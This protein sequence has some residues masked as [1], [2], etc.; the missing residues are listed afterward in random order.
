MSERN[1]YVLC[2]DNC[3]FESMTK[4]QILAAITDAVESGEIHDVDTGFVT[5][6]K[7][8]NKNRQLKF[9]VGT[10]AEY[11]QLEEIEQNVMY[12]ISDP[13]GEQE[14]EAEVNELKEQVDKLKS[15]LPES[16]SGYI[17]FADGTLKQWGSAG[18]KGLPNIGAFDYD[19]HIIFNIPFINA[20][21]N[22]QVT[23]IVDAYESEKYK[24]S[25]TFVSTLKSVDSM[26]IVRVNRS[27]VH[28]GG[29]YWEA[30][31]RWY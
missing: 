12:L 11:N 10:Q 3:R 13:H 17:K 27:T 14:L 19:N 23:T 31:G 21:Y 9:W 5:K 20:Q 24:D 2:D 4:E 30:T 8:M 28:H 18:Y 1:Y 6:I 25:D 15:S 7:E 22:V 16:G 26:Y 29:F